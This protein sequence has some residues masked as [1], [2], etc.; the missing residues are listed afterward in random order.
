M[1]HLRTT[2]ACL[3]TG[4]QVLVGARLGGKELWVLEERV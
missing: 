1:A 3:T 4:R 2:A